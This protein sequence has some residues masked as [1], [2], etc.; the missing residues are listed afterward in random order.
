MTDSLAPTGLSSITTTDALDAAFSGEACDLVRPDGLRRRLTTERWS[1]TASSSDLALFIRRCAGPTLDLG[2]GP[3]RLS[4]ALRDRGVDVL[5]VDFSPEA[6]R[7]T[8]ARGARAI[9]RDVFAELPGAHSW[10]HVLLADGNIGIG[11]R[12]VTL[13]ERVAALLAPQGTA[14]VEIAERGTVSVHAGVRLSVGDRHTR[15]FDWATVGVDAIEHVA[16][17]ANLIVTDLATTSGRHVATLQHRDREPAPRVSLGK[18]R[19]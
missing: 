8:L 14:L 2:C 7:Q 19:S 18:E 5:G 1:G 16:A 4:G 17:A 11:G 12:P 6:V 9:C 3:G 10:A 15:P 13:L